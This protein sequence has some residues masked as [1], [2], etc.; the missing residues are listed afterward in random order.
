MSGISKR[1]FKVFRELCGDTA[2]KNARIVTNMWGTV[3]Q[4]LGERREHQLTTNANLFGS[5]ID[6]GASVI[7][8]DKTSDSAKNILQSIL[9]NHPLP[10]RIQV[11]MVDQRLELGDTNAGKILYEDHA[12]VIEDHKKEVEKIRQ[13]META[14]ET[15]RKELNAEL[16]DRNARIKAASDNMNALR[17]NW[18]AERVGLQQKIHQLERDDRDIL[19]TIR[20]LA[21]FIS[22]VIRGLA[23]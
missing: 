8:H 6:A 12:K 16:H 22:I 23:R 11:D 20:K 19:S 4:G 3:E 1:N 14:N 2:L 5:A 9:A 17:Y 10:L 21:D 7:R 13:E 15:T 18:E